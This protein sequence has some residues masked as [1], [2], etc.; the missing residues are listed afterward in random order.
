MPVLGHATWRF[1][2]K[3]VE[4]DPAHEVPI[5]GPLSPDLTKNPALRL[6]WIFLDVLDV[7]RQGK[8]PGPTDL[9]TLNNEPKSDATKPGWR[10]LRVV[11]WARREKDGRYSG[12]PALRIALMI[13]S[14]P[15]SSSGSL[16][17]ARRGIGQ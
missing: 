13:G 5:E 6:V 12:T 4:R 10:A 15:A 2:R 1:Y 16:V 7:L 17:K 9:D 11:G 14:R 3:A 8:E